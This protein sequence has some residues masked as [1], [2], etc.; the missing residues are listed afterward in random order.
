MKPEGSLRDDI[1]RAFNDKRYLDAFDLLSALADDDPTLA[2]RLIE[3]H[4]DDLLS[5]M[6]MWARQVNAKDDLFLPFNLLETEIDAAYTEMT[7]LLEE[8]A[9]SHQDERKPSASNV[10]L[11]PAH[12]QLVDQAVQRV[13]EERQAR[14]AMNWSTRAELRGIETQLMDLGRRVLAKRGE[15]PSAMTYRQIASRVRR[16]LANNPRMREHARRLF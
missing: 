6:K 3:T 2:W 16:A 4:Q 1:Q 15:N 9:I 14:R 11:D 7:T 5:D 12:A 13:A 8:L 10:T